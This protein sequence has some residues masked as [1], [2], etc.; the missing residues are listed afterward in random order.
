MQY[1]EKYS[2]TAD[3]QGDVHIFESSQ[4][5]GLYVGELLYPPSNTYIS[6]WLDH[7]GLQP[8]HCDTSNLTTSV[9]TFFQ[10]PHTCPQPDMKLS[11]C[12]LIV[13]NFFFIYIVCLF[14]MGSKFCL[15]KVTF[16]RQPLQLPNRISHSSRKFYA[17]IDHICCVI[18]FHVCPL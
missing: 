9:S 3:I 6:I 17:V 5:K 12:K 1:L 13:F 7:W 15:R 14:R 16:M 11:V 8:S 10:Y 2:K 18:C 4:L